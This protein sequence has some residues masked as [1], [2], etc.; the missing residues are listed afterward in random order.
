MPEMD[1]FELTAAVR[2]DEAT[3]A[4]GRRVPIIALTADA[5]AGTEERCL[6]AGMD[7]YLTKPIRTGP[8]ADALAR[9]LPAAAALRRPGARHAVPVA[10]PV[11]PGRR[12]E[13]GVLDIKGVD[14][15]ILDPAALAE[16]FGAFDAEAVAFVTAFAREV[17][18]RVAALAGALE[19]ADLP[20]A[21]HVA[22][23][24]K[25]AALSVGAKRLGEIASGVQDALDQGDADA[26]AFMAGLLEPTVA[27]LEETLAALSP[28][29]TAAITREPA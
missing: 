23:A 21:R 18:V 1:G 4:D 11:G 29:P 13:A 25:G 28:P 15:G 20:A 9:H 19:Q 26:A 17:P 24:L 7:G 27:E 16:T 10:E 3:A 14:T 8:L 12:S 5:L 2:A 22:H 6:Q